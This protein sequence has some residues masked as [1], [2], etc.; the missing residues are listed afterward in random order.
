MINGLIGKKLGMTEL[1]LDD[2]T[3]V[4]STVIEAGPCYVVQT[5][6]DETDGYSSVQ[7]AQQPRLAPE[8]PHA[9]LVEYIVPDSSFLPMSAFHQ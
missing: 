2:G 5:K 1:F 9:M 6:N 8:S 4:V 3:V 7:I